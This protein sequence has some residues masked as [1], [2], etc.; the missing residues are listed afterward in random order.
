MNAIL[1]TGIDHGDN[2][3]QPQTLTRAA[4]ANDAAAHHCIASRAVRTEWRRSTV[5]KTAHALI[6]FDFS[7]QF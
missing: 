2:D 7:L 1:K 6:C 3:K 4:A 5:F